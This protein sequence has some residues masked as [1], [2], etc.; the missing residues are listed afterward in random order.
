[1]NLWR[2]RLFRQCVG[3]LFS[4]QLMS[5]LAVTGLLS[6]C[7]D[8]RRGGM[9]DDV[10]ARPDK[11]AEGGL[12]NA[13]QADGRL[14]LAPSLGA[15]LGQKVDEL[16]TSRADWLKRLTRPVAHPSRSLMVQLRW[17]FVRHMVEPRLPTLSV[18]WTTG[19]A[20]LLYL[21]RL[22]GLVKCMLGP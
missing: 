6:L 11:L 18:Q 10:R 16:L 5:L 21:P 1:M 19:R 20:R 15:D 12:S 4:L 22:Y 13:R 3:P 8:V 7:W 9:V 2:R 14:H 17:Q